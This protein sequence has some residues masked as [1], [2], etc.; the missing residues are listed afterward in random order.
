MDSDSGGKAR[1]KPGS[2]WV[3][4]CGGGGAGRGLLW[5]HSGDSGTWRLFI[6]RNASQSKLGLPQRRPCLEGPGENAMGLCLQS[7]PCASPP[8]PSS[9]LGSLGGGNVCS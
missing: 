8:P 2:A 5:G 4:V 6:H 9:I 7:P 1:R 3:C